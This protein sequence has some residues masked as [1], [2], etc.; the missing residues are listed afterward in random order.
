VVH[1]EGVRGA[2]GTPCVVH[3][4]GVRGAVDPKRGAA[5]PMRG[6]GFLRRDK[7]EKP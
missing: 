3:G 4:E 6:A 5:Y 7:E 1:G 2:W